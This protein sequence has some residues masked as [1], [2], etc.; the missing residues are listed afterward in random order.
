[1]LTEPACKSTHLSTPKT[2]IILTFKSIMIFSICIDLGG[3]FLTLTV[4]AWERLKILDENNE[5]VNQPGKS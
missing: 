2:V 3:N 1:M 5:Y 4:W